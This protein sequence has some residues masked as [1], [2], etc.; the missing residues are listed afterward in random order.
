MFESTWAGGWGWKKA[1][2]VESRV[3]DP[4]KLLNAH[5]GH[6]LAADEASS[7]AAAAL[8]AVAAPC[9]SFVDDSRGL[10]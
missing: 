8:S 9:C 7:L 10:G 2:K 6:R 3:Q 5:V 1:K 4:G